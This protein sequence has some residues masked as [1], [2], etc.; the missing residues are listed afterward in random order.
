MRRLEL[1][2]PKAK[3]IPTSHMLSTVFL[4]RRNEAN[5]I[6]R[7]PPLGFMTTKKLPE[8]AEL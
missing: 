1:L 6:G 8:G 4:L 2:S 7:G 5:R 3:I